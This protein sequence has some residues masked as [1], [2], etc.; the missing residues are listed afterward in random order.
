MKACRKGTAARS[1]FNPISK[2]PR[3][4]FVS[5]LLTHYQITGFCIADI[6]LVDDSDRMS[7]CCVL[8]R[9]VKCKAFELVEILMVFRLRCVAEQKAQT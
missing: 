6:Y 4:R 5:F 9:D 7:S 1:R 2:T 8:W 3:A